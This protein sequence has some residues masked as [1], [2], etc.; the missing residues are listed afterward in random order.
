MSGI[1]I[2]YARETGVDGFFDNFKVGEKVDHDKLSI[3]Q[4][5]CI[6]SSFQAIYKLAMRKENFIKT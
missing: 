2:I 6:K 1:P 5:Q 3:Y 4:R